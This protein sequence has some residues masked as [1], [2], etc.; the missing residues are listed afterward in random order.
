[1]NIDHAIR[2]LQSQ[3]GHHE[4]EPG[5]DP[6]SELVLTVLTQHTSDSNALRAFET[7]VASFNNWESAAKADPQEIAKAIKSAGLSNVKA[8]RIK[9]ILQTI[10]DQK[11]NLD[12]SFLN[13]MEASEAISWLVSL[14]G[15]GPKTARCV[16]LFSL[17]KPV[18]PVDTH[19][20]RV[21]R[22]LGLIGEKVSAEQASDLL[23]ALVPLQERYDFHVNLISHGRRICRAQRQLCDKCNFEDACPS[24]ISGERPGNSENESPLVGVTAN[25]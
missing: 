3:H 16:L 15:V 18:L 11:G 23:E 9:L 1:M 13:N 21:T 2:L 4:W 19:V 12:L 17:G 22:R 5:R 8:P 14:P 25:G 7:L 6:T 20:H 24:S 10:L